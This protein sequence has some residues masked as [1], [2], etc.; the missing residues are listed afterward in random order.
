MDTRERATP[1]THPAAALNGE[2]HA[3]PL[4][5]LLGL[6]EEDIVKYVEMR[7]R[8]V[9]LR[10]VIQAL[11]WSSKMIVLAVGALIRQHLVLAQQRALEIVLEPPWGRENLPV[12]GPLTNGGAAAWSPG[13]NR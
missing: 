1:L 5:A 3:L 2:R 9:T 11:P 10:D 8:A 7:G 6:V 12:T 13:L 4:E